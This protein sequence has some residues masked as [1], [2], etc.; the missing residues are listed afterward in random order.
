PAEAVCTPCPRVADV[1]KPGA[2]FFP[3]VPPPPAGYATLFD[4]EQFPKRTLGHTNFGLR[5]SYLWHG[6]DGSRFY[7]NSMDAQPT[8]YRSIVVAPEPAFVYQAR[9]DRIQQAGG[10]LAKD[11]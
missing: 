3:A 8:F 7:Y 4:N 2:E 11:L 9:H 10:T 6:W 5:L 1:A